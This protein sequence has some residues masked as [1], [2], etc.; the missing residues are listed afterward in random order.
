MISELWRR[1]RVGGGRRKGRRGSKAD[2]G[3]EAGGRW[4]G[5]E[6]AQRTEGRWKC[7]GLINCVSLYRSLGLSCVLDSSSVSQSVIRGWISGGTQTR[8][9]E[10][11]I[12]S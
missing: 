9:L 1:E 2:G 8:I 7:V 5:N 6:P 3:G 4:G 12:M 10:L 11:A